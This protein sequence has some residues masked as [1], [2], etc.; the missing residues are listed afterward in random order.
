M[1]NYMPINGQRGSNRQILRK[2]E[3][4]KPEPGRNKTRTD[5][6]QAWNSKLK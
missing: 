1:S 5:Q 4:S 2:V 3:P 6:S